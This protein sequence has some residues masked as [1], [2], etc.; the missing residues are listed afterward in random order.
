MIKLILFFTRVSLIIALTAF[1]ANCL[2]NSG[3]VSWILQTSTGMD[4]YIWLL[5]SWGGSGIED[6]E[7]MLIFLTLGLA[8]ATSNLISMLTNRIL[9]KLRNNGNK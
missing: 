9:R 6:G 8:L 3:P 1:I 5:H 4:G 2:M 7:D